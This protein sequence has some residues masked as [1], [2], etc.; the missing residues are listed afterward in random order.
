MRRS[1]TLVLLMI[2]PGALF[3][4]GAA[5]GSAATNRAAVVRTHNNITCNFISL[6]GWASLCQRADG[7]GDVVVVSQKIV[8][9][10]TVKDKTL[11]HRNQPDRLRV[12]APL[13]DSRVTFVETHNKVTCYWTAADGGSAVCHK[14]NRQGFVATI[15]SRRVLVANEAGKVVFSANQP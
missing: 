9:V 5:G 13:H 4:G 3:L 11:F 8:T 7:T 6:L 1:L 10:R 2:V 12:F 15:S 14:A